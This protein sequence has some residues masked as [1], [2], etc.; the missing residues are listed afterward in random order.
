[1]ARDRYDICSVVVSDL[2]YDAR[3]WKEARSLAAAGFRVRLVGFT[4]DISEPIERSEK[5]IDSVELPF[6]SRTNVSRVG[7]AG[8]L[9]RMW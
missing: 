2:R 3:V 6:G 5:G 7:R 4:Y 8:S 9:L 1:M